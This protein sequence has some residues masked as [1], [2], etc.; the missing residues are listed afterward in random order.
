MYVKL[1]KW[2]FLYAALGGLTGGLLSEWVF[3]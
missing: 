1:D 2:Y 3:G